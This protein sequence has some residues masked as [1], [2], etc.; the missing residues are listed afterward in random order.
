[1]ELIILMRNE[2]YFFLLFSFLEP[3]KGGEASEDEILLATFD[4]PTA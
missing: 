4:L 2:L 1:M 3:V